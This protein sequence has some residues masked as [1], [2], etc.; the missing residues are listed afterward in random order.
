MA[1]IKVLVVLGHE[2]AESQA[3]AIDWTT[4]GEQGRRAAR[5]ARMVE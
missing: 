2:A 4:W 1:A 5:E 3:G